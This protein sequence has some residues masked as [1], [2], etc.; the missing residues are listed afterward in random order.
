MCS[1][2]PVRRRV[3]GCGLSGGLC[4]RCGS[5]E[6]MLSRGAG[7]EGREPQVQRATRKGS[8]LQRQSDACVLSAAGPGVLRG[9]LPGPRPLCSHG[10]QVHAVPGVAALVPRG[11]LGGACTR[12]SPVHDVRVE[13]LHVGLAG[14]AAR[15]GP[16][17]GFMLESSSHL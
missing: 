1:G 15:E 5:Q 10:G 12:P 14:G 16:D 4:H 17:L 2:G 8:Q 9:R 11:E 13:G 3:S 7:G 6:R